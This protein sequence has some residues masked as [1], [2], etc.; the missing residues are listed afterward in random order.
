MKLKDYQHASLDTLK[1]YLEEARVIGPKAA[2]KK[3]TEKPE[4]AARL[5][6]YSAKYKPIKTLPDTPYV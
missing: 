1:T 5:R 6:G 2:Y 4:I 3:I